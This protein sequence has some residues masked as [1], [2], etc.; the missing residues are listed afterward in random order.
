MDRTQLTAAYRLISELFLYPED[1][2]PARIE[3]ALAALA[4]APEALRE[5][6]DNFLAA[7]LAGSAEE[8]V[9]TLELAPAVSLYIGSHLYE[10]PQ[11]CRGAGMSGRNGYMLEIGNIYRHFGV[12]LA[13]GELADFVP[14][15]VEFLGLSLE[16]SDQDRI[17]LRRYFVETMLTTGLA[18]LLSALRRHESPYAHLV[19]ALGVALAEDIAQMAGGPKWQPPA[20]DDRRPVPATVCGPAAANHTASENGAE[21]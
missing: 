10:E 9:A 8:Y 3:A 17:G 4:A 7:P 2:D 18:S 21:L 1:R 13:G 19:D 20:D 5:P 11:S 12:E 14:V 15:M 6:L 16:R